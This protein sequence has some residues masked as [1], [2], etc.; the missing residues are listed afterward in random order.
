MLLCDCGPGGGAA[1]STG[2]G[3]TGRRHPS[4]R[5]HPYVAGNTSARLAIVGAEEYTQQAPGQQR[6]M[7]RSDILFIH[8]DGFGWVEFRDVAERDGSRS[9]T[10]KNDCSHS[11]R[12]RALIDCSRRSGSSPRAH[13]STS[14]PGKF[15]SPGRINLPLTALRFLRGADQYRSSFKLTQWNRTDQPGVGRIRRAPSTAGSSEHRTTAR[16]PAGSRS[17][18]GP[19]V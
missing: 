1:I 15:A 16:R 10:V 11:S 17:I 18:A 8:D 19:A 6:R 7:L 4:R 5:R 2:S 3:T 13:G 12:S 14:T 9:G